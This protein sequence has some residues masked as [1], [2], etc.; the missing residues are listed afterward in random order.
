MDDRVSNSAEMKFS[1]PHRHFESLPPQNAAEILAAAAD[2]TL[3]ISP[4]GEVVDAAFGTTTLYEAGGRSWVNRPLKDLVTAECFGKIDAMIEEAHKGKPIRAREINHLMPDGD[5]VPVRYSA[6]RIADNNHVILFGRDISRIASLQQKLM[7]SQLSIEREFSRLRAAES[8]YRTLFQLSDMPQ[9]VVDAASLRVTD[10]NEAARQMLGHGQVRCEGSKVLSLFDSVNSEVLHKLL[11]AAVEDSNEDAV[12][13]ALR[14]GDVL[15]IGLSL[16]R[17]DRKNYLLMRLG[18]KGMEI[19]PASSF[20]RR[21][22]LEMIDTM[23]DAMVVADANRQIVAVNPAFVDMF[24]LKSA[25]DAEGVLI[26]N[27][28]ERPNV[29]C[30]VLMAN[31]RE[32]GLV[33]RFAT[34]MRGA[35]GQTENVEIAACVVRKE[36]D[37]LFGFA[38]RPMSSSIMMAETD[39]SATTRSDEQ[40]TNLVGHMPLKDIVRET[41]DMIEKLCIDTALELT[42]GNRASAAQMLGLSRQSLYAKLDKGRSDKG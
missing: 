20:S 25:K 28:F 12:E 10:V 5:D 31:V 26:D 7:N 11:L 35:Y 16:F 22:F 32:H 33:K 37:P 24:H 18:V 21:T 13:I 4:E 9:I 17:E 40:I 23:S 27:W 19:Q 29:D 6:A 14:N 38:I 41:T 2:V 1:S 42:R 3:V 39:D 8:R 30:N 36:G 15:S 34:V